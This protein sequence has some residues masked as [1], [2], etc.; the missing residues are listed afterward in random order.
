LG[1]LVDPIKKA[2]NRLTEFAD[3]AIV[4]FFK[5]REVCAF[6]FFAPGIKISILLAESLPEVRFRV[7][8]IVRILANLS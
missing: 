5:F 3:Q 1:F 4:I 8:E 2:F 6:G 7:S